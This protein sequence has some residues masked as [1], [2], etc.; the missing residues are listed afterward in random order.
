LPEAGGMMRVGIPEYR[1]PRAI[2]RDEIKVI[3]EHGVQIMLN[4]RVESFDG[5]L[6]DGYD[7]V[8]LAIGAHQGSKMRVHGEDLPGVMDGA[9]FLRE[10]NLGR[11]VPLGK[12]VAVI[13]GGNSAIDS[14]RVALRAGAS[15][16]VMLYRRTRAEMPAANEEIEEALQEGIH[17]EFLVAPKEIKRVEYG[18]SLECLRMRLGK[19]D[20]SG[21]RQPE[22]LPGSEFAEKYDAVI[23][24]IG[25]S[26]EV[27]AGFGIKVG[28]G[29]TIAVSN[30][31]LLDTSKKGVFAA[32][33][34]VTGP[35]SVI[36]A[37]AAGRKAATSID[38][39]LGGSGAIDEALAPADDRTGWIGPREGIAY[40]AR[41]EGA[42]M[43]PKERINGFPEVK[44]VMSEPEIICEANRCLRCDLRLKLPKV[45]LPP[46]QH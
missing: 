8:L 2:L 9:F 35:A 22:P 15:E 33:D 41:V 44:A 16:V 46:M 20:P 34:A 38:I 42:L 17:I 11:K 40:A 7:A 26:P 14:A 25:Q 5:L 19:P 23:A 6:K 37:I 24:A 12:K 4:H 39:Y 28:R 1:L 32:G 43:D 3:E 30:D 18:I 45:E 13:G 31:E 21:R 29:N 10:V 27:P 36:E